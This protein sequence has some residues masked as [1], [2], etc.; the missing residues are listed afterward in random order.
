MAQMKVRSDVTGSVWKLLKQP[1]ERVA[2]GEEI[3]LIESMKMEIPVIAE[4]DGTVA[5]L[6]VAESDAVQEGQIVATLDR[7]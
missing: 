1:G 5:E 7:D 3:M 6:L 2:A 4:E